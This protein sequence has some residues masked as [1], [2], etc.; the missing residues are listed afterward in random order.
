M[1]NKSLRHDAII[2]NDITKCSKCANAKR[3]I[4]EVKSIDRCAGCPAAQRPYT[5]NPTEV[6]CDTCIKAAY[7]LISTLLW[8]LADDHKAGDFQYDKWTYREIAIIHDYIAYVEK[9]K[10]DG[11][12]PMMLS[13]WLEEHADYIAQA[14]PVKPID[15]FRNLRKELFEQD[16]LDPEY[17]N[18][19]FYYEKQESAYERLKKMQKTQNDTSSNKNTSSSNNMPACM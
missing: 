8:L 11:I 12:I 17:N 10:A 4:M 7:E 1:S 13:E 14:A 16:T 18:P 5:E 9:C 3:S 6:I 2:T 19:G 15:V